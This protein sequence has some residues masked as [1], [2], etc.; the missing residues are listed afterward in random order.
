[1]PV[2]VKCL[3]IPF[4]FRLKLRD[5]CRTRRVL[6][7][8]GYETVTTHGELQHRANWVED[9][10]GIACFAYRAE[11]GLTHP[12]SLTRSAN[13][14]CLLQSDMTTNAR[15][16]IDYP[17]FL[18]IV[19]R[20]GRFDS[21]DDVTRAVSATLATLSE[22]RPSEKLFAVRDRLPSEAAMYLGAESAGGPFSVHEFF[23]RVSERSGAPKP[24]AIQRVWAVMSAVEGQL[25]LE[26][27]SDL[28]TSLP[29]QY[30][31]LFECAV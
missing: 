7:A 9:D 8:L 17:E 19:A 20:R 18:G 15:V 12:R 2:A 27:T 26:E 31:R 13:S 21:T 10:T 22:C 11:H 4:S 25:T 30:D 6:L 3:I 1:M 16:T 23:E 24:V 29:R 28:R 14:R 5:Y